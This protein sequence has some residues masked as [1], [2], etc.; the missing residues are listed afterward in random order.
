VSRTDTG[1][2]MD[3]IQ[4]V[5]D[6]DHSIVNSNIYITKELQN[7][8]VCAHKDRYGLTG[9]KWDGTKEYVWATEGHMLI[10]RPMGYSY[11]G[12]NWDL[13]LEGEKEG[14]AP[15]SIGPKEYFYIPGDVEDSKAEYVFTTAKGKVL[16][17]LASREDTGSWPDIEQVVHPAAMNSDYRTM[18]INLQFIKNVSKG[19]GSHSVQLRIPKDPLGPVMVHPIND[20][21]T[22]VIT[23]GGENVF[24][25]FGIAMPIRID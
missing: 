5:K 25:K 12:H 14:S 4:V 21:E 2:E 13:F 16:R 3:L 1:E 24:T 17:V 19:M 9:I 20:K 6:D 22:V 18:G 10:M 15:P 7:M 8:Q 11:K 23:A